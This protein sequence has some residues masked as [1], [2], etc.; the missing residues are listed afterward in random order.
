MGLLSVACGMG[1]YAFYRGVS[2]ALGI[3]VG[4]LWNVSVCFFIGV[5]RLLWVVASS[6]YTR[7]ISSLLATIISFMWLGAPFLTYTVPADILVH[8]L[9]TGLYSLY[10]MNQGLY[11]YIDYVFGGSIP[12]IYCTR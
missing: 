10:I 5:C 11:H 4:S 2:V 12:Y 3:A 9:H 6:A 7:Y 1:R 8:R